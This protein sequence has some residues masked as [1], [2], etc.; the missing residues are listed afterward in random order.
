M[1][2][3]LSSL[4]KLRRV[5]LQPDTQNTG[6]RSLPSRMRVFGE[7]EDELPTDG[8]GSEEKNYGCS[9]EKAFHKGRT[10]SLPHDMGL[11]SSLVK[12]VTELEQKVKM[13][14]EE[15]SVKVLGPD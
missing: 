12:R 8:H 7:D 11:I 13:Q 10:G 3:P 14:D 5:P 4:S 6:R 9:P 1:S 15:N 2:S